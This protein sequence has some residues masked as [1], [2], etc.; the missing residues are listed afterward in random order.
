MLLEIIQ[1]GG[2]EFVAIFS[3][4]SISYYMIL[5]RG[6]QINIK[7]RFR[8]G[9]MKN[10][11]QDYGQNN[12]DLIVGVIFSFNVAVEQCNHSGCY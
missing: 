10:S 2:V 12:I 3:I 11:P 5:I 1:F 6:G 9:I 8:S 4:E 7:F